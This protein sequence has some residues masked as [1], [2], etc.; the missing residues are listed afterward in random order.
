MLRRQFLTLSATSGLLLGFP[1]LSHSV[2]RSSLPQGVFKMKTLNNGVQ[3]PMLGLGT[4]LIDNDKVGAAVKSA[5][6]LGY[7]HIDTAQ[8]YGNEEGIGTAIKNYP[9]KRE[10][11]FIT[12]KVAAELKD[13]DSA[14]K[15]I[16]ESLQKLQLNYVDLMI[17]HS[18]QP[19]K[20][21]NQSDNRYEKGNIEAYRALEDA[22][23]EK[24]VRAIGVSN[25]LIPDLQNILKNC[26]TRPAVNQILAHI[27]NT[28]FELID[29]CH[30]NNI[31][32][33]AYSP[34][35]HG[36]ILN[37]PQIKQMAEKYQVSTAQLAIKY[38][39]QLDLITLPKTANP[40][41]QKSNMTLDF[42]ISNADM[43]TLKKFQPLT[44]YGEHSFFPVF[45]GKM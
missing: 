2:S 21:V 29:F 10:E 7:R 42:I 31:A 38:C 26:K 41:H 17:I 5:L 4:W 30:K 16:D 9:I 27:G 13:Y 32:V 12:T 44:D 6:D 18:P 35:G 45:G 36:E 40:K 37:N 1:T 25:F 14:K 19:W 20:E 33:E 28:P 34:L 39:L 24:K 11:L 8:A 3:I 43:E 23:A 22:M 15:S